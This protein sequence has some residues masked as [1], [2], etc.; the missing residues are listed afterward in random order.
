MLAHGRIVIT[1]FG[2]ATLAQ[3]LFH[4]NTETLELTASRGGTL[5]FAAPEHFS[6]TFGAISS[7]TDIYAIGGLAFYMLTG[8][9]P[10]D[11]NSLLDTVSDEE[12]CLPSSNGTSA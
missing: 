1:D 9:S 4:D 3:K 6:P 5:G 11:V 8:R 10:H 12:V 2:F 7:A